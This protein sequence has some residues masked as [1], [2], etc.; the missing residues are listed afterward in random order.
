MSAT[1][2]LDMIGKPRA[3][4]DCG[5][6]ELA[7]HNIRAT[8]SGGIL[9]A[10]CRDRGFKDEARR[11]VIDLLGDVERYPT[12][13][14]LTM[15]GLDWRFENKLLGRRE[16]DWANGSRA[17]VRTA[18]TAV[19]NDRSIYFAATTRMPG[20]IRPEWRTHRPI[21]AG[22]PNP[23]VITLTPPAYAEHCLAN[24]WVDRY[25]F[26]NVD[27]LLAAD[28]RRYDAAWL[29]Y[30]GPLTVKRMAAI[31]QFYDNRLPSGGA[32]A[33][34]VLKARWN[35]ETGAAIEAAGGCQ[36]WIESR[37]GSAHHVMEYQ[38]TGSPMLQVIVVKP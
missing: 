6:A 15:P 14:V 13:S 2:T 5:M 19:E 20:M 23:A 30:T 28:S 37:L 34:T 21:P 12:L 27:D 9:F 35:R 7:V 16:G 3:L 38:D 29:D 33:L 4:R 31:Q 25:V 22:V 36:A 8:P 17:P 18:I 11:Y 32:L 10:R 26:A 1:L 24:P